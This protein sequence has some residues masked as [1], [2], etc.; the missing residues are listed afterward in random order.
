MNSKNKRIKL[1]P[2]GLGR[3]VRHRSLGAAMFAACDGTGTLP[4]TDCRMNGFDKEV[5]FG[6]PPKYPQYVYV[7]HNESK[8][9][10]DM[11]HEWVLADKMFQSHLD[12]SFVAHQYVIAAQ[13]DSAVDLPYGAVGLRRRQVR[14][15]R[16]RSRSSA[17]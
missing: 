11:A 2:V 17:T 12:E 7:P 6:G 13:A 15:D 10:F 14:Q 9:Y 16:R 3:L 5:A 8:P 1:K 4:G